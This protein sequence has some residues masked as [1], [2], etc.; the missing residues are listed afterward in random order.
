MSIDWSGRRDSKQECREMATKFPRRKVAL[1]LPADKALC[2]KTAFKN[3]M[4]D[5]SSKLFCVEKQPELYKKL[6]LAVSHDANAQVYQCNLSNFS[7][8]EKLDYAWLDLNGTIT[9]DLALWIQQELSR[10]VKSG[11][12][13]CLTHAVGWRQN[14]WLKNAHENVNIRHKKTYSLFKKQFGLT[15]NHHDYLISFPAFL[16]SCLLRDWQ[17]QVLEPFEYADTIN[18]VFYRFKIERIEKN[19]KLPDLMS[20]QTFVSPKRNLPV[21]TSAIVVESIFKAKT[22]AQKA[23]ATKKLNAYVASR[24]LEG[25]L[26]KQIRAGIAASVTKRRLAIKKKK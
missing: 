14:D 1:F 15:K 11:A 7:V 2:V 6:R 19:V 26:E 4:I 3:K 5:S 16:L 18:M 21:I 9:E 8:P 17:I 20:K 23:S 13:L 24:V 22:P 12:I 10:N 25:K